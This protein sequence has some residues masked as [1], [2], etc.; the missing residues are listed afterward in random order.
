VSG[1]ESKFEELDYEEWLRII[2][3]FPIKVGI[4][5]LIGGEPFFRKD[6]VD[7]INALTAKKIIV[8]VLTNQTYKRMLDV[9]STPFV[10]FLS[11]YHHGQISKDYWLDLNEKIKKKYRTKTYEVGQGVCSNSEVLDLVTN[12]NDG[13]YY[14]RDFIFTP[15][16]DLNMCIMDTTKRNGYQPKRAWQF[17]DKKLMYSIYSFKE[18]IRIGF[19]RGFKFK[20]KKIFEK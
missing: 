14:R 7:L 18:K 9:N 10:K 20:I 11:T 3:N 2:D 16:G 19:W 1:R 4:V 17:A 13:C 8:K 6:S 12:E 15:N 5:I